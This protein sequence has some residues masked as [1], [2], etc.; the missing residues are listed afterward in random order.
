[1]KILNLGAG[2]FIGSHLTQR[3]LK[4]GHHVTAVNLHTDKI[5][6]ILQHPNLTFIRQDIRDA[7]WHLD[8]L[9]KDA[10]L[11]IDLI[12]HANPGLYVRIPSEVTKEM[13]DMPAFKVVLPMR[14]GALRYATHVL[15]LLGCIGIGIRLYRDDDRYHRQDFERYYVDA[16][17]LAHGGDPWQGQLATA[18]SIQKIPYPPAFF[19][20]FSPLCRFPPRTAHWI[21]ESLQ[22]ACLVAALIITLHEIGA[23]ASGNFVRSV[24][25]FAFL[26][27]PLQNAIHWGQ[28]TALLL[29][30][31]V[32]SWSCA[33]G[34]RDLTAGL[35]LAG[36]ILLKM[37]PVAVGGYFLF[38]HRWKVLASGILFTLGISAFL[39]AFYG[40]QRNLEFVRDA[41]ISAYWLDQSGNLSI[42]G[43]LHSLLGQTGTAS[44]AGAILF[45]ALASLASISLVVCSGITTSRVAD[46]SPQVSGLCWSFWMLLAILLSPVAWDHYLVLLIPM[47]IFLVWQWLSTLLRYNPAQ[48]LGILLIGTGLL[49]F[50]ILPYYAPA[51]HLHGDLVLVLAS[52]AGL[53]LVLGNGGRFDTC[54]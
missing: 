40:F 33:R 36:A 13:T 17:L 21:W 23:T 22:I 43:N 7:G 4:E 46:A 25:A 5:D 28:P 39:L 47:Y 41:R 14:P 35:L 12:A 9:V 45:A 51:R 20:T 42:I 16:Y 37:F 29:L 24:F 52:Y 2:G 27:P 8:R 11:V 26:F 18:T 49:G 44:R 3:L 48:F 54:S 34:G 1:M 38:R 15:L 53:F 30:L 31:L 50:F 10:D 19:F 32:A 6:S